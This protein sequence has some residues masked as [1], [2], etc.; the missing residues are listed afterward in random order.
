MTES[1]TDRRAHKSRNLILDA[2]ARWLTERAY[3]ELTVQD[4]LDRAHVGRTTFYGHFRSKEELLRCSLDRL[5]LG[6]A[7]A[8]RQRQ[9]DAGNQPVRLAFA[10]PFIRHVASHGAVYQSFVGRDSFVVLERYMRRMLSDL[11]RDDLR[12]TAPQQPSQTMEVAVQ[13][14]V[15]GLWSVVI[16]WVEHRVAMPAD[17]LHALFERL[18]LEGLDELVGT[19]ASGPPS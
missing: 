17:E 3:D 4:V 14:V 15:G 16:W 8:G 13:H 1:A 11:V 5:K 19:R 18:S 12:A 10:L 9:L 6:L 7:E 2:F